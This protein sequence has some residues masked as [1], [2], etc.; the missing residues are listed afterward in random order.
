MKKLL[1]SI[2]LASLALPFASAETGSIDYS[3]MSNR[4]LKKFITDKEAQCEANKQS[5]LAEVRAKKIQECIDN[6]EFG[7]DTERCKTYY[8]D[9]G[10]PGVN[11]RGYRYRPG[12]FDDL[13]ECIEADQ[14]RQ[15]L[16]SP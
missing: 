2:F 7:N 10:A 15:Y 5:L 9:Y 13:P 3:S 8:S 16:D 4:E 6:K 12:M 14:A 1:L 11:K